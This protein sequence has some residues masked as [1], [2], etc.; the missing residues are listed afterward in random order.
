MIA[1]QSY[2]IITVKKDRRNS[3]YY[4]KVR[5]DS[6]D[7]FQKVKW[8]DTQICHNISSNA[9]IHVSLHMCLY[10]EQNMYQFKV[11][12][13]NSFF[14][15]FFQDLEKLYVQ[16]LM[17]PVF[18]Y[19]ICNINHANFILYAKAQKFGVMKVIYILHVNMYQLKKYI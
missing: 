19:D 1:I 18:Y 7:V 11:I 9:A 14:R 10:I 4:G 8:L 2:H 3:I 13:K 17:Y 5:H 16:C 12:N 15:I 6:Y